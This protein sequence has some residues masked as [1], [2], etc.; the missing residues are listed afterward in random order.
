MTQHRRLRF[1]RTVATLDAISPLRVL[2]RGYAVVTKG[3]RGAAVT[4]ASALRPGDPVH[5]RF[6]EGAA[7]CRV[8]DIKEENVDGGKNV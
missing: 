8:T 7:N 2:G 3:L 1:A 4:N 6:A 5:I